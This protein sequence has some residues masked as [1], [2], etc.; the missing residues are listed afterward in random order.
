MDCLVPFVGYNQWT[1]TVLKPYII[2]VGFYIL[3]YGLR[4]PLF[5]FA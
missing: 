2:T 4:Q 5:M 3:L 1:K